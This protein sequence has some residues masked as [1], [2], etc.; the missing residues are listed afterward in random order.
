M[1]ANNG[2]LLVSSRTSLVGDESMRGGFQQQ[3]SSCFWRCFLFG[4]PGSTELKSGLSRF[5]YPGRTA[6]R[7]GNGRGQNKMAAHFLTKIV[8][9]FE[10]YFEF[11]F[12]IS[13]PSIG[14]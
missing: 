2:H 10:I 12:S 1:V 13:G 7:G 3:A 6:E 8:L 4:G 9:N 11:C 14:L 5:I